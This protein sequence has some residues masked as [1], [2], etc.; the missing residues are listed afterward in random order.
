YDIDDV[1]ERHVAVMRPLVVAPAQVQPQLIRRS[2][3]KRMIERLD[4]H[5][6]LLA[7]LLQIKIGVLDV[8][9]HR[10]VGTVDLQH[11]TRLEQRGV[12]AAHGI[13]DRVQIRLFA[14]IIVVAKEERDHSWR[15]CAYESVLRMASLERRLQVLHIRSCRL[16]IADGYGCVARRSLAP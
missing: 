6:R 2:V 16:G 13:G 4:V 3:A 8:A 1:P 10:E 15:S 14:W 5:L 7:E 12:L 9:S 11:E